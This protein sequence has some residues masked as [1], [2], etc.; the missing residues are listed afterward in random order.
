M[1][2]L[3]PV[4]GKSLTPMHE[5]S[6]LISRFKNGDERAFS[7]LYDMYSGAIYHVVLRMTKDEDLSQDLLQETFLSIWHKA[8]Q[9]D[10]QK[11]RF[12]TWAY[13]IARH[14]VLN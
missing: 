14:K 10:P 4:F 13:R 7:E 2:E 6:Q 9:Y 1:D 12:Y 11:G 3:P 8:S 5:E